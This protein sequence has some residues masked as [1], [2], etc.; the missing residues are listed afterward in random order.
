MDKIRVQKLTV[1]AVASILVA[2][3]ACTPIAALS[4]GARPEQGQT[5]E[6]PGTTSQAPDNAAPSQAA[7]PATQAQSG[8]AEGTRP[9]ENAPSTLPSDPQALGQSGATFILLR[10][11]DIAQDSK[12]NFIGSGFQPSESVAL[13]VDGNELKLGPGV[14]PIGADKEGRINEVSLDLPKDLVPGQHTLTVR[15]S[16]SG[17]SAQ[18]TFRLQRVPPK[19]ELEQYTA[20]PEQPFNF[21]GS[22]FIPGEDV[23]LRLGSLQGNLLTTVTA[24]DKGQI[25]GNASLPLMSGGDYPLFFV[26]KRSQLPTSVGFNAQDF[27]PWI[28]LDNYSPPPYYQM[29][30]TAED[31]APGEDVFVYLNQQSGDPLAKLRADKDGKIAAKEAVSL[32]PLKGENTL[33]FVGQHTGKTATA[34]FTPEPF[35]PSLELTQYSVRPGTPIALIGSGW[36][37]SEGLTAFIGQ[38]KERQQ[39]S[40]FKSDADGAFKG[41]GA[42]R[43]PIPMQPGTITVT[44]S[45]AVSQVEVNVGLN[46]LELQPSAELT[47]YEGLASTAV[48]FSGNGFAG[49]EA[50]QVHLK[51][52]NGEVLAETQAGDDGSFANAGNYSPAGNPGDLV[53]F[54]MVGK[55]S[56]S[57]AT[58]NFR[59]TGP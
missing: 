22:G 23:D 34:K 57:Q 51:D 7:P 38:G 50:V 49:G 3:A 32:A 2:I 48:H 21:T 43:I 26:G 16:Q 44:V 31:F 55:D 12:L 40:S 8:A 1:I 6:E 33:I 14:A 15:G 37:R 20:K 39:V 24:D 59:I 45:G 56:G 5:A 53:T 4:P 28:V 9:N 52:A 13:S 25:S 41:D 35:G 27:N 46:I 19:I 42:F 54:V 29:G 30:F 18:A 11:N 36:A 17:K 10:G 58:T 47:A